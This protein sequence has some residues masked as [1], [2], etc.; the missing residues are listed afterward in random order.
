MPIEE[1]SEHIDVS[2]KVLPNTIRQ[3]AR[4]TKTEFNEQLFRAEKMQLLNSRNVD[5]S[6]ET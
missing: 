6:H 1:F 4:D 5:H 2:V 3:L